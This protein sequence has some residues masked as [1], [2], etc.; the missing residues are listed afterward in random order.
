MMTVDE[1]YLNIAQS[2]SN[3]IEDANWAEAKLDIE[4]VANGVV[5][6][7]GDYQVNNTTIDLSVRK[8]PRDV[9]NW[10]RELHSVTTSGGNNKWNRAIFS[11][12]PD[13]KFNIEFIW[14]QDLHDEIERLAKS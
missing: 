8:I 14:D 10:L 1:I 12:T 13:G 6:Y 9:R 2:I 4:V 3:A 7:T 11:L 5:A